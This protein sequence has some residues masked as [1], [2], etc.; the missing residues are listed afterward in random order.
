MYNI[1]INETWQFIKKNHLVIFLSLLCLFLLLWNLDRYV[2]ICPYGV[3]PAAIGIIIE[4]F[5]FIDNKN[6]KS[7]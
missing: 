6:I 1:V 7:V 3:I 5:V 4:F 2:H